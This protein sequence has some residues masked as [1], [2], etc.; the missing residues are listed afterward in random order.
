[1]LDV[2][3]GSLNFLIAVFSALSDSSIAA[4]RER[5]GPSGRSTADVTIT[6]ALPECA[7][8]DCSVNP[9]LTVAS[10]AGSY[11]ITCAVVH[12]AV[13]ES[14]AGGADAEDAEPPAARELPRA[15][16]LPS[17]EPRVLR[18]NKIAS[19]IEIE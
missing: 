10:T 4:A 5:T 11:S 6:G 16:P 14:L 1:M 3:S 8:A 9:A 18:P 7:V 12:S 19:M 13:R 2:R 15:D 17:P